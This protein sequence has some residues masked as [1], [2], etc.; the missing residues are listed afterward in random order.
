[1]PALMAARWHQ[2][3]LVNIPYVVA[4]QIAGHLAATSEWLM[5]DL[6]SLR[7]TCS[8]MRHVCS[9]PKVSMVQ[10]DSYHT[11]VA[12]LTP[13]GNPE[14]YF[15]TEIEVVFHGPMIRPFLVLDENLEHATVAANMAAL[16]LYLANGAPALTTLLG[17]T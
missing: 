15:I 11:L 7:V 2:S 13:V 4:I 14:A 16:L 3:L 12:H 17:S 9:E 6:R 1:M 5:S 10:P 8:F